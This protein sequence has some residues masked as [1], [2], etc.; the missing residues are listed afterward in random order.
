MLAPHQVATVRWAPA[1]AGATVEGFSY[2]H[3]PC[4]GAA[5]PPALSSRLARKVTPSL[6][7]RLKVDASMRK[8]TEKIAEKQSLGGK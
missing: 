4:Y 5:M 1:S 3:R 6:S 8:V 2:T 7:G